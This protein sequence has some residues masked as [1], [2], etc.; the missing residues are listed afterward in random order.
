MVE[1]HTDG[2]RVET[3]RGA[4][5]VMARADQLATHSSRADGIERVY[6]SPEH[7][8]VNDLAATWM[9]QAGL[10]AW[11]D[12]A[13]NQCGRRAGSS[14]ELPSVLLGS[15]LDT[16]PGAGRYDGILGVLVAI[17]VAA[18]LHDTELPFALE[19]VAFG[20]E[21]GTRFGTTLL[22]SHA[23]AG[24][25]QPEWF[26]L[27]DAA[28]IRLADAA[29]AF[30]LDPARF[31]DAARTSDELLAYLEVHIEQGPKLEWADR[32]L[33]V[34]TSIAAAERR[35]I[36]FTGEAR[37]CATP[38]ELRHDALVGASEG[39]LAIERIARSRGS[40]ATVGRIHV[41][42]DAVN[43]IPGLATF[44]LD[45]R[46][47]TVEGRDASWDAI[48]HEMQA[49]AGA[50]GLDLAVTS[51]HVAPEIVCSPSLQAAFAA[52]IGAT[53]DVGSDA[54]LSLF[55]V[56]GHDAMAVAAVAPVG[57]LFV[58]CRGGV[59][60][61]ADESVREAD[62]ALAIDALEAAVLQLAAEH[63]PAG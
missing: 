61:H 62:V 13:G 43:V 29:T 25:W 34:V 20:D 12:A 23:L 6:L 52:G 7:R 8:A 3:A 41:E 33:G 53:S 28:G 57:M 9:H 37:H 45:L 18:R 16:V 27:V 63:A 44:S 42:P 26:E 55:S 21:E 60:H 2:A 11:E 50:R 36:A 46:D 10:V 56:A 47:E 4:E 51:T 58:R 49:I 17:E 38:W 59:S 54:P 14:D 5:R 15:H 31:A 35:V 32:A 39:V 40:F 22:G 19:V 48:H 1:Q 30:G 24:T